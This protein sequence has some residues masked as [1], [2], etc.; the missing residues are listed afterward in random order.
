MVSAL[1]ISASFPPNYPSSRKVV[2]ESLKALK[3][4][5]LLHST[6]VNVHLSLPHFP[7]PG[8]LCLSAKADDDGRWFPICRDVHVLYYLFTDSTAV[9]LEWVFR[10]AFSW[11]RQLDAILI[12]LASQEI[13]A[14]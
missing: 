13:L 5:Q 2:N 6:A 14:Y 9:S 4:V 7:P 10:E 8:Q 3:K 1:F 11:T 12:I